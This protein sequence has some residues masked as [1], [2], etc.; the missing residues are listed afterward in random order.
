MPIDDWE[1]TVNSK[2]PALKTYSLNRCAGN[3]KCESCFRR[4][5]LRYTNRVVHDYTVS[6][7]KLGA[8]FCA[9]PFKCSS[10]M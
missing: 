10:L 6:L 2:T 5:I 1:L 3:N 4:G 8:E 9:I 7:A